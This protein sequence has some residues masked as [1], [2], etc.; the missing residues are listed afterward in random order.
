MI[1]VV[2]LI[3][4]MLTLTGCTTYLKDEDGKAIKNPQTGQNLPSNILCQPT[5]QETI[6]KYDKEDLNKLPKCENFTPVS[7]GYE[8][9]WTTIFVKPLAWIIIQIG[10]IVKNYGLACAAAVPVFSMVIL[11]LYFR[12]QISSPAYGS[13]S[14]QRQST[15]HSGSL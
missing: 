14:I 11:P 10:K 6:V 15:C 4:V 9:I 7:G 13:A 2:M 5:E 1:L 8:G 12:E 3:T